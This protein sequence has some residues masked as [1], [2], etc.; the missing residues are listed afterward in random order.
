[1]QRRPAWYSFAALTFVFLAVTACENN[2]G[3]GMDSGAAGAGGSAAGGR[4]GAGG[5]GDGIACGP[6]TCSPG[7]SCVPTPCN[8]G[9]PPCFGVPAEGCLPGTTPVVNCIADL[10]GCLPPACSETP[11]PHCES[12]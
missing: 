1:M 11:P 6:T 3:G 10:P 9:P 5:T 4:G 7:Q 12:R 8:N 2:G